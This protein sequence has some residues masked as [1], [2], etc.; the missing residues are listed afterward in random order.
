MFHTA[1]ETQ[2][3]FKNLQTEFHRVKKELHVSGSGT[4]GT[5]KL[6]CSSA[7]YLTYD[8][9]YQLFFPQGG[10][11]LPGFVMTESGTT[12]MNK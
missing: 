12:F 10:S 6:R 9:Y 1:D 8:S 11:A 3:L 5:P 2:Q 4:D 7:L